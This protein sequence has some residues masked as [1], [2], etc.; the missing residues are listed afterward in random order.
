MICVYSEI[1]TPHY[2]KKIKDFSTIKG[3]VLSGGPSTVTIKNFK[4]YQSKF[5]KKIPILGIC[6]G[7]QLIAKLF[8]GKI[9]S[10][11]KREFGR[12][13]IFKNKHSVLTKNFSS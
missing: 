6:Y 2:I 5:F 4:V 8:G 7:L 11:E 1:V 10:S 3:I 9:K 12:A 13:H